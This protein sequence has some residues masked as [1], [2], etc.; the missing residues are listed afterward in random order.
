MPDSLPN[1]TA[2][3]Q[4][5]DWFPVFGLGD[6]THMRKV[7]RKRVRRQEEGVNV[8][9]DVDAVIAINTGEGERQHV[10]AKSRRTVRQPEPRED[11]RPQD[12]PQPEEK[13]GT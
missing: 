13:E 6:V 10:S 8:A 11:D 1:A 7:V 5:D 9:A 3:N 2:S 4:I 12:V